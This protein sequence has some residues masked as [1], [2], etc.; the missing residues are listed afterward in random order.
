MCVKIL[1]IYY[2]TYRIVL[3]KCV[4]LRTQCYINYTVVGDF[5]IFF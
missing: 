1:K 4:L 2:Y 5:C 3:Y